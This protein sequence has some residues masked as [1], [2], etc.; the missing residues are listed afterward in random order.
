MPSV[1]RFSAES[2]QMLQ[3]LLRRVDA[4]SLVLVFAQVRNRFPVIPI[5]KRGYDD[6]HGTHEEQTVGEGKNTFFKFWIL[7]TVHLMFFF[8]F[9]NNEV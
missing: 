3:W 7:E 4:V 8:L 5:E 6:Q 9:L 2:P 1:R